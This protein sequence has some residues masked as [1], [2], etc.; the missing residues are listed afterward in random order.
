MGVPFISEYSE[1]H[2][3]LYKSDNLLFKNRKDF[4][5]KLYYALSDDAYYDDIRSDLSSID[6][7]EFSYSSILLPVISEICNGV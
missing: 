1:S 3:K 7:F 5:D 4:V 2:R 6:K